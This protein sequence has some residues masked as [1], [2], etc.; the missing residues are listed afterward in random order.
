VVTIN[1][2]SAG[3]RNSGWSWYIF[4]VSYGKAMAWEAWI[5]GFVYIYVKSH[6]TDGELEDFNATF[7]V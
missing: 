3:M 7:P 6:E 4:M 5:T 2:I 1:G